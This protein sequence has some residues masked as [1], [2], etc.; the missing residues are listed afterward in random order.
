ML[1]AGKWRENVNLGVAFLNSLGTPVTVQA[2]LGDKLEEVQKAL[3]LTLTP[4]SA[5]NPPPK[6]APAPSARVTSTGMSLMELARRGALA[7]MASA[8]A[9]SS[10]T[11][12]NSQ[13][14]VSRSPA[15][16]TTSAQGRQV[17]SHVPVP[18]RTTASTG[19]STPSAS[20]VKR[21]ASSP[22][23]Q[24]LNKKARPSD[25]ELIEISD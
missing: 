19:S 17:I 15:T 7:S 3:Q 22:A 21:L 10:A 9:S 1:A 5:G 12:S 23:R 14:Q 20:A 11:S 4:P 13:L 18:A 8:S 25:V 6:Q 16:A 24:P 2:I